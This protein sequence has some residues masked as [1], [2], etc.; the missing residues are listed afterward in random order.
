[1]FYLSERDSDL[2]FSFTTTEEMVD[3]TGPLLEQKDA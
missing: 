3:V 2:I 1:M